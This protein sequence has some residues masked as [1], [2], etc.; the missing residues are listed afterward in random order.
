MWKTVV[1]LV[2][3]LA[4]AGCNDKNEKIACT[5]GFKAEGVYTETLGS[6]Y[7]TVYFRDGRTAWVRGDCVIEQMQPQV[8][9]K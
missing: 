6:G 1:V 4:L 8:E 3:A 7:V 2:G 5:N 9:A